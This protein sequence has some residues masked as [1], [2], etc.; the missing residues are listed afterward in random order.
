MRDQRD[1]QT[2]E[3][4]PVPKKRGRPATGNALTTAERQARFRERQKSKGV[5]NEI[6]EQLQRQV[7][8]LQ[9]EVDRLRRLLSSRPVPPSAD[10]DSEPRLGRVASDDF[11][12]SKLIRR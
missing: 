4:L 3:M 9:A 12:L 10:S 8:E 1:N 5:S 7:S 6:V 2:I 11:L